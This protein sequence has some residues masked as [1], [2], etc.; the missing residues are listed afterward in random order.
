MG[1]IV[2]I[3]EKLCSGCGVCVDMCPQKILY[4]DEKQNVCKVLDDLRCDQRAGCQ[5]ACPTGA[6]KINFQHKKG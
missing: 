1:K 2:E 4:L 6:I 5:N 3:D